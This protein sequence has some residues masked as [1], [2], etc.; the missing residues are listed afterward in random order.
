[1]EEWNVVVDLWNSSDMEKRKYL[2]E[3]LSTSATISAT[4]Q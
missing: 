2:D 3:S 1:M 4:L